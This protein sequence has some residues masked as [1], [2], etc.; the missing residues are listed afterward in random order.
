MNLIESIVL[1][2]IQGLTEFLPV[3]SSGHLEL[4][5]AILGSVPEEGMLMT[6]VLHFATA[7]STVVIF[8]KDL[9]T[10][11]RGLFRFKNNEE[12]RFSILIILSMIPAAVVGMLF[13]HQIDAFFSGNLALVGSMLIVTGGLLLVADRAKTT[14]GEISGGKAILV[15]I[16]QAIAIIPGISRSGATIG[17]SVILGIDRQKAARFS[18]LMVVPLILGAMLIKTK[19][20]MEVRNLESIQQET[21]RSESIVESL[22]DKYTFV[23]TAKVKSAIALKEG[24][25]K[26]IQKEGATCPCR[27]N[28]LKA[29][30]E[31]NL[32]SAGLS[33]KQVE[34]LTTDDL[35]KVRPIQ[36]TSMSALL[37]GFLAAFVTGLFACQ[38][39]ISIVKK[40]KLKYFAFYCFIAGSLA[41]IW[42]FIV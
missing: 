7:L 26:K 22:K 5:K 20:Y 32:E 27:I 23:N 6:I 14:D 16:A 38:W 39:M 41:V 40:S 11:F 10:I 9:A 18:F 37:A 36:S 12:L 30:Y 31:T 15:G 33:K 24:E 1:G 3:S 21:A 19:D 13:E 29:D 42:T 28:S 25:W 35:A 8:R 4:G 34:I 17:T 2:V